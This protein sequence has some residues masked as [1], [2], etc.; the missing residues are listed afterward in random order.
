MKDDKEYKTEPRSSYKAL[1][2]EEIAIALND[3]SSVITLHRDEIEKL[4]RENHLQQ[5]L[6]ANQREL[7]KLNLKMFKSQRKQHLLFLI[8]LIL[9]TFALSFHSCDIYTMSKQLNQITKEPSNASE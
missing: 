5:M 3:M 6:N 7:E 4:K 2:N 8:S 9:I 1:S